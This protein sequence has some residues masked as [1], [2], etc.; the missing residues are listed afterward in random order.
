MEVEKE[1]HTIQMK[2]KT[3]NYVALD[4]L[5]HLDNATSDIAFFYAV[6]NKE[7]DD[8]PV[9]V[10]HPALGTPGGYYHH[11]AEGIS[12]EI[13]FHVVVAEI[14]GNGTSSEIPS[15]K[16]DWG[17]WDLIDKDV[18]THMEKVLEYFPKNPLFLVGHSLGGQ[19]QGLYTSKLLLE[20]RM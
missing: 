5:I 19:L 14:R 13:G 15:H 1:I 11:L 3:H 12:K 9:F 7:K 18:E 17:Y 10:V 8:T 4:C 2:G 16:T 20:K 6:G